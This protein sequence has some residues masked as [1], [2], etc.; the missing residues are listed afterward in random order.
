MGQKVNPI[1][2]RL[3]INQS[4]RSKWYVDPREY[5]AT[6]HEDLA[7]RKTIDSASETRGADIA[8]VEIIRHPQRIALIIHTGRPGVVI[9]AK[10]QNIESLGAKLQR[11]VGK[12]IQIK[13]KEIQ[14]PETN[15]QLIAMNIARQLRGRASF[16]R[17]MKMAINNAMRAG[18]QG[19]KIRVAGRLNGAEMS[20][21]QQYKEGRIPLHTFRADIDYGF[22]LA[23]TTV[24]SLGIKVW[25]F[26]GEVF[27]RDKKDD[28]GLLL[29]RQRSREEAA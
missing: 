14:R 5:A 29:K 6:L 28:A 25:V 3:G 20:R 13:I 19:V 11:Q 27:G 21:V 15:A 24:G 9:G 7:L 2:L 26:H 10:G 12:K 1:G 8:Q 17:A 18:V 22:T 4:W 16:R 23:V